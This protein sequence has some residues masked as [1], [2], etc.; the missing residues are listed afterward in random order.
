VKDAFLG[1]L[2]VPFANFRGQ[3]LFL[4]TVS[5]FKDFINAINQLFPVM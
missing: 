5:A 1:D 3:K 2:R 4:V